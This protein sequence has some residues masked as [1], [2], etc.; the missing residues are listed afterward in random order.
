MPALLLLSSLLGAIVALPALGPEICVKDPV[1]LCLDVG[2]AAKCGATKQCQRAFWNAPPAK[3]LQ[4]LICQDMATLVMDTMNHNAKESDS[5][6]LLMQSCEWLPNELDSAGCKLMVNTYLSAILN[7]LLEGSTPAMVCTALKICEPLQ[8]QLASPGPLSKEDTSEALSTVN[9]NSFSDYP[10]LRPGPVLC[11]DCVP[12]VS[13]LQDAVWN[14][15]TLTETNINDHCESLVPA[16][17]I[18]CKKYIRQLSAPVDQVLMRLPP[19]KV[20]HRWR[21]CSKRGP[22]HVAPQAA[23]DGVPLLE[24]GMLRQKDEILMSMSQTCDLCLRVVRQLNKWLVSH[25]TPAKIS[26]AL[27]NVCSVMPSSIALHCITFVETYRSALVELVATVTPEMFC[28]TIHLCSHLRQ[29]REVHETYET[30]QSPEM[31]RGYFCNGCKRLLAVSSHNLDRKSTKQDILMA[32]KGGC[33]VL[34]LPY[35]IQ[36]NRFVTQYEP[37]L[38]ESLKDMMEPE[39]LCKKVG[40]CHDPKPLL[41]GTDQCVIGPSFWCT[42]QAAA[43]LCDAVQHCQSHVWK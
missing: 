24:L 21:L 42:S 18:L 20:C 34:P 35:M 2:A 5:K 1:Q 15:E 22:S 29:T 25:R 13:Q 27:Q 43:E 4:C 41:L 17:T 40:A 19:E 23:A 38:I 36:C 6:A 39:A 32:F 33:S 7:M 37:V 9:L 14:N 26:Q 12:L 30:K 16:L 28:S 8:R 11:S 31:N 3:S 10:G